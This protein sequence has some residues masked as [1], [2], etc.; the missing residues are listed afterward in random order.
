MPPLPTDTNTSPTNNEIV[1]EILNVSIELIEM[2]TQPI[3]YT[4][5]R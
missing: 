3:A 5:D 2:M 4:T 1:R